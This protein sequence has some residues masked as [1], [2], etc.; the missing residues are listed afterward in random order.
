LSTSLK[1]GKK[2]KDFDRGQASSLGTWIAGDWSTDRTKERGRY[3][4]E[5]DSEESEP[6]GLR[7]EDR[8]TRII[9]DPRNQDREISD[10]PLYGGSYLFPHEYASPLILVMMVAICS[11]ISGLVLPPVVAPASVGVSPPPS[12]YLPFQSQW[13][14]SE[15]ASTEH[16]TRTGDEL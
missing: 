9:N 5:S 2:A 6:G 7:D 10:H 8:E 14:C 1:K 15:K 3:R 16:G 4:I 12:L 11:L 13:Q